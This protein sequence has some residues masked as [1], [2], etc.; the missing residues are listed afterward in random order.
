M[1]S[2]LT[3]TIVLAT[4][5]TAFAGSAYAEGDDS[6]QFGFSGKL[7]TF[8]GQHNSGKSGESAYLTEFNEANLAAKVTRG[9]VKG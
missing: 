6:Y 1:A 3:K 7:R 9:K 8:F 4:M 2:R 5:A